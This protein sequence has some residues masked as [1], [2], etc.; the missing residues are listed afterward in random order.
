MLTFLVL[1]NDRLIGQV[2]APTRKS[3]RHK[4]KTLAIARNISLLS[5]VLELQ[6][7]QPATTKELA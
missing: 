5:A 4:A 3:A 1:V 6:E 2:S 7:V